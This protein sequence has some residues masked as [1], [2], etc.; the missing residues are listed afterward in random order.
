MSHPTVCGQ[1]EFEHSEYEANL[2]KYKQH[3]Q[4]ESMDLGN[5]ALMNIVDYNDTSRLFVPKAS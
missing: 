2:A 1:I 5:E 4:N 3:G